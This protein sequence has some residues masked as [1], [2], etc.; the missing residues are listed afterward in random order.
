MTV[1]TATIICIL[2]LLSFQ[3]ISQTS[4]LDSLMNVLQHQQEDTNK[5]QTYRSAFMAQLPADPR[6]AIEL[7]RQGLALS[8][9][10]GYNRG[11]A[12]LA[13][14]YSFGYAK[15]GKLD[16][17][18][19]LID[20]AIGLAQKFND[21]DRLSHA[22]GNK[23]DILAQQSNY[24]EAL[25][26]SE[27]ALRYAIEV[28]SNTRLAGGYLGMGN[29]YVYQ[30]NYEAALENY[31]KALP[32][33]EK[34]GPAVMFTTSLC[35][36]GICLKNLK[37][38]KEAIGYINRAIHISD[39]MKQTLNLWN[40]YLNITDMYFLA[41]DTKMAEQS[42]FNSL[43]YAEMNKNEVQ[44]SL[45]NICVAELY[46]KM[47]KYKQA[48]DYAV[49]GYKIAQ[50][51][52]LLTQKNDAAGMLAES[53]EKLG[54]YE[55]AFK[56]LKLRTEYADSLSKEKFNSELASLQTTMKVGEKEKEIQL[57]AKENKIRSQEV[58][59]QRLYL[60]GSV[61]ISILALAGIW[62]AVNRYKLR[63]RL[64]EVQIRTQ[65]AADLHDEVGSSLSSIHLLSQMVTTDDSGDSR[66][67]AILAR[68][69]VNAKETMDKMGDIVWMI[70]PGETEAA[71][72]RQRM[73]RF[74]QEIC[75]TK[76][77]E[78]TTDLE[79][80]DKTKL[81]MEQRKNIYL[82]FKEAVNNAVKYSGTSKI[83]IKA[84]VANRQLT[85]VVRDYGKGF[86]ATIT[87]RGN[88]LETMRNRATEL[89]GRLDIEPGDT[90][91]T[92]IALKIPV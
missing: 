34:N 53:Y 71:S 40:F 76:G 42:A 75:S 92:L 4:K 35:N 87:G 81:S 8:K 49:R 41:G 88:G 22:Y 68:M 6:K 52:N 1:Q 64:K 30:Q 7:A 48:I 70:K 2:M 28:K 24:K 77:I 23:S 72:M 10:L 47:M 39:S 61:I 27:M 57:L 33:Y 74:A 44:I 86:D 67:S 18:L 16:S 21:T 3:G 15:A 65:I 82:V 14:N 84:Y 51:N 25:K 54:N 91:G 17:A 79:A 50:Q 73:E 38:Y 32:L 12:V 37:Q 19:I 31:Q 43:R 36:I 29:I 90:G 85:M 80:A 13:I 45:A 46:V 9:K 78:V 26:S 5:V 56:Y 55:D 89:K 66:Q 20:E 60:A 58:S 63:Q 59:Q 83:D 11:T 69:S 62:L